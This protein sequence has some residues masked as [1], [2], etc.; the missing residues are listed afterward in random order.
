[1]ANDIGEK[2]NLEDIESTIKKELAHE[3]T[4]YLKSVDAQMPKNKELDARILWP[5]EVL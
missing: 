3:L 4:N 5:E 2:Q 1:M